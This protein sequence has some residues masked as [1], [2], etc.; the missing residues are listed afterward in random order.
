MATFEGNLDT[1]IFSSIALFQLSLHYFN[2]VHRIDHYVTYTFLSVF[3]IL[4]IF[5]VVSAHVKLL[6]SSKINYQLVNEGYL[7]STYTL[8]S[9]M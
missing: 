7:T 6:Q 9:D 4:F 1:A 8:L 5:M 2:L 3:R